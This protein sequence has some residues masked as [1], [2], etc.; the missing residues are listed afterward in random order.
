MDWPNEFSAKLPVESVFIFSADTCAAREQSAPNDRPEHWFV[1][2]PQQEFLRGLTT[3]SAKI[4]DFSPIVIHGPEGS[5][6][7]SLARGIADIH[8]KQF[9]ASNP[10]D[11]TTVVTTIHEFDKRVRHAAVVGGLDDLLASWQKPLCWIVDDCHRFGGGPFADQMLVQLLDIRNQTGRLTIVCGEHSTGSGSNFSERLRSRLSAG[12]VVGLDRPTPQALG[13]IAEWGAASVG[14]CWR[15]DALDCI[16][17]S[18]I[19]VRP[20]LSFLKDLAGRRTSGQPI[21]VEDVRRLISRR[22]D[23]PER[24]GRVILS[25]VAKHFHLKLAD[26][27]GS[28]RRQAL[29]KARG[30]AIC[31]LRDLTQLKWQ[32]IAELTGRQDHSTVLHA[33]AKTHQSMTRDPALADAHRQLFQFLRPRFVPVDV[34][35]CG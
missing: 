27:V 14:L 24:S 20:L 19:S 13:K 11:G 28:S 29:V 1:F 18:Q 8:L 2:G 5:G 6:K 12:L 33:Y 23:R 3:P 34:K 9:P 21:Q 26:L 17:T 32:T 25:A 31:L 35:A 4:A 16:V 7:S 30:V 10:S 22:A 15:P